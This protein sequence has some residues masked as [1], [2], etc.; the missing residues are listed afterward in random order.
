MYI[1]YCFVVPEEFCFDPT[2]RQYGDPSKRPE[3]RTATVEFIAPSEYMVSR[4]N[5]VPETSAHWVCH[6]WRKLKYFFTIIYDKLSFPLPGIFFEDTWKYSCIS[7]YYI[8]L[9]IQ[10]NKTFNIRCAV[11]P[12]SA[13]QSMKGIAPNLESKATFNNFIFKP[14]DN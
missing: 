3:V 1:Y 13:L 14:G 8:Y 5:L 2:T 10:N 12:H 9:V 11:C 4:W 6:L 7:H